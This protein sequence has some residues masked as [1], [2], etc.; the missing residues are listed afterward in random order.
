MS[1][2]LVAVTHS[3]ADSSSLR[4]LPGEVV[5]VGRRT[6]A[7]DGA[8]PAFVPIESARGEAGWVPERYLSAGRPEAM[9][10]VEC[11]TTELPAI[12]GEELELLVDDAESGWS[13][14]RNASGREGWI[15]NR[16]LGL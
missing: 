13:W 8:W 4:I 7:D 9:V 6:G 10:T 15:P 16:N 5:V 1:K 3:A 12:A 2:V 14:C 11:N